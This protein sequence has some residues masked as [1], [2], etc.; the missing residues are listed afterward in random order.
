METTKKPAKLSKAKLFY[1]IYKDPDRKPL[2]Q[3]LTEISHLTFFNKTIPRVYFSRYLFK[4]GMGNIE[5]YIPSDHLD[6]ITSFFNE[7]DISLTL[8]NKLYFDL[9]Y[10]QFNI[11]LPKTIMYNLKKIFFFGTDSF[12]LD[13]GQDFHAVLK[14]IFNNNPDYDSIIIKK[15]YGSYGGYEIYKLSKQRCEEDAPYVEAIYQDVVRSGFLFQETIIQHEHVDKLNPSCVNTIR[16][17]TFIDST[18]KVDVISGFI[19]INI[20]DSYLDNITQ[21]GYGIGINLN[22]GTLK[23]YGYCY[24]KYGIKVL[25]SHPVTGT[26]FEGFEIPYFDQVKELVINAAKLMPGLRLVG[27]DVAIE[28]EGPVLIEGNSTYGANG[29]DFHDGGYRVNKVYQNVMKEFQQLSKS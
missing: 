21:G 1:E 28:K 11:R 16:I 10:K 13:N 25:T 26:V 3:M 5:N 12:Q 24:P 19:R 20:N 23:K 6:R 18:G 2:R 7:K 8:E 27:W 22:A 17:D 4:K 15:M 9:Y 14:D 29:N